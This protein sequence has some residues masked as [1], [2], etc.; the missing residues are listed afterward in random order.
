MFKWC[1]TLLKV[2]GC[3]PTQKIFVCP[4]DDCSLHIMTVPLMGA[5]W[6]NWVPELFPSENGLALRPTGISRSSCLLTMKITLCTIIACVHFQFLE[7]VHGQKVAVGL[8]LKIITA[9]QDFS[10]LFDE[11]LV[12]WMGQGI[13]REEICSSQLFCS[14]LQQVANH[15]TALFPLETLFILHSSSVLYVLALRCWEK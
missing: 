3:Q 7:Q 13:G 5:P 4:D 6:W 10:Y 12:L 11:M 15:L 9:F 1:I 14:V 2:L 8:Y